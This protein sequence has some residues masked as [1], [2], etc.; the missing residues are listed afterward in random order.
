MNKSDSVIRI[1]FFIAGF[2]FLYYI[3]TQKQPDW[4]YFTSLS[5]IVLGLIY[6]LISDWR[7]GK[8]AQV[9]KRLMIYGVIIS[10]G[11]VLSLLAK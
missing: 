8:K 5:M 7:K 10:L 3:F 11:L 2:P 9:K 1:F 6:N 4:L